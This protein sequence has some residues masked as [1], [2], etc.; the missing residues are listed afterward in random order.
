MYEMSGGYF[1]YD[2]LRIKDIIVEIESILLD[3]S[4][5]NMKEE[6]IQE[7]KK[8]LDYLYK[9]Y[10]YTQ[11]IDWFLSGDDSEETFHERL[12]EDLENLK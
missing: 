6:T 3:D 9:A 11:R 1:D 4:D 2:Q 8:G 10:I 5:Y 7:F 12:R